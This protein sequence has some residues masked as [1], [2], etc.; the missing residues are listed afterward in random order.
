MNER[1]S[2]RAELIWSGKRSLFIFVSYFFFFFLLF[3]AHLS[4]RRINMKER[5]M[6]EN[7]STQV[8]CFCSAT[9]AT[10]AVIYP[11]CMSYWY[12]ALTFFFALL[13]RC[14]YDHYYLLYV[15]SFFFVSVSSYMRIYDVWS[16]RYIE[17]ERQAK[18]FGAH[19]HVPTP[20]H[21]LRMLA[22][23]ERCLSYAYLCEH[24]HI[25]T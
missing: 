13:L 11:L 10:T 6:I 17:F 22:C 23:F 16:I 4:Y 7:I 2:D 14:S 24:E 8:E 20:T 18:S 9:A 15:C 19:S 1:T 5:K 21:I 3:H 12:A 25:Y